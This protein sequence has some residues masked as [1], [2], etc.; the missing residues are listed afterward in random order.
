[1]K[2]LFLLLCV[3]VFLFTGC[4]IYTMKTKVEETVEGELKLDAW[5]QELQLNLSNTYNKVAVGERKT[6]EDQYQKVENQLIQDQLYLKELENDFLKLHES[7]QSHDYLDNNIKEDGPFFRA[8]VFFLDDCK[9]EYD[10]IREDVFRYLNEENILNRA[11]KLQI[12]EEFKNVYIEYVNTYFGY[13]TGSF[14]SNLPTQVD[15]LLDIFMYLRHN[16]NAWA[17]YDDGILFDAQEYVDE[18]QI[19]IDNFETIQRE[20]NY[21]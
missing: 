4:Y 18:F 21:E 5:V 1:M 8:S 12:K 3:F 2:K 6:N 16:E 11:E 17:V 9:V 14:E 7:F 19:L 13:L 10:R 15:A 20:D